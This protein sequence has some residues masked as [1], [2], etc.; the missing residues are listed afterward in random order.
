MAEAFPLFKE[1]TAL[2]LDAAEMLDLVGELVDS[3]MGVISD[4]DTLSSEVHDDFLKLPA[5][6]LGMV[7]FLLPLVA[8]LVESSVGFLLLLE[9]NGEVLDFDFE[10]SY[11]VINLSIM[12]LIVIDVLF[13]SGNLDMAFV[14]IFM[15]MLDS[16]LESMALFG[17]HGDLGG[18]ARALPLKIRDLDQKSS[19]LLLPIVAF[20]GPVMDLLI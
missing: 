7:P 13:K 15:K 20:L 2:L 10:V 4:S 1:H 18:A 11:F 19:V 14:K 6:H 17:P 5:G 8:S 12:N 3:V 9:L 16:L